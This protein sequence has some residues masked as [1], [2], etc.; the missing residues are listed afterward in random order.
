MK[1]YKKSPEAKIV[2]EKYADILSL[3]RPE[4]SARHPRM[5][6]INRAKIFSPF[7][8]LRGYDDELKAEQQ[9]LLRVKKSDLSEE[10]AAVLSENLADLKKGMSVAVSFFASSTSDPS[11]GNYRTVTGIVERI[12]SVYREIRLR[13]EEK[14]HETQKELPVVISFEDILMLDILDYDKRQ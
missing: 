9:E 14:G 3:S 12:D 6:K 7:A 11:L 2:M 4:P 10:G 5:D 1:D 8:A 13:T